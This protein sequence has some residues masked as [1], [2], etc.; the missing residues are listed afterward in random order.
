MIRKKYDEFRKGPFQDNSAK[1]G[2]LHSANFF[3]EIIFGG[4]CKCGD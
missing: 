2:T 4:H 1:S 3:N